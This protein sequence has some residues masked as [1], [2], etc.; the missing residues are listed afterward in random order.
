[1]T[2]LATI[3]RGDQK[4]KTDCGAGKEM[5]TLALTLI[6]PTCLFMY[7]LKYNMNHHIITT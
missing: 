3:A 7:I 4:F 5:L 2:R 6:K 1:M